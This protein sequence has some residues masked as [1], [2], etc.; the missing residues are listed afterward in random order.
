VRDRDDRP[1]IATAWTLM[2]IL[3]PSYAYLRALS[4]TL[5]FVPRSFSAH[6]VACRQ[7]AQ[8]W[9]RQESPQAPELCEARGV[10]GLAHI[11]IPSRDPY[12]PTKKLGLV[13]RGLIVSYMFG[14]GCGALKTCEL[15]K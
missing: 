12:I 10:D 13:G 8:Q 11:G 6:H 5:R 3:D 15:R 4:L 14:H 2:Q 1:A 7:I 9:I